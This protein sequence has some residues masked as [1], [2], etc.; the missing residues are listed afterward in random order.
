VRR[1]D[2]HRNDDGDPRQGQ[3]EGEAALAVLHDDDRRDEDGEDEGVGV[4]K[5]QLGGAEDPQAH[6]TTVV[7]PPAGRDHGDAAEGERDRDGAAGGE[8][9]PAGVLREGGGDLDDLDEEDRGDTTRR[10]AWAHLACSAIHL[11]GPEPVCA[12]G[13]D[14]TEPGR[15]GPGGDA[16][17]TRTVSRR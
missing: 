2:D 5:G 15:T 7:A 13:A 12:M 1:G 16:P 3:D 10:Q 14:V 9:V 4:G 17:Q 6:V 11:A 8:P